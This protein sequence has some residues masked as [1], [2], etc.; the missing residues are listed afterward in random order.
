MWL[1]IGVSGATC[2]GKSSLAHS[3][4]QSLPGSILICQDDFFLP[5]D[6][7]RH[8]IIP[9]LRHNNWEI[10]SSLDMDKMHD[11][12]NDIISDK[13]YKTISLE[14]LKKIA[15]DITNIPEGIAKRNGN[16]EESS[17]VA[18]TDKTVKMNG[19]CCGTRNKE[20]TTPGV[21]ILIIEGFLI[22]NDKILADLCEMKYFL[23]LDRHECWARRSARTYNPPDVPGYFDLCVWPEYVKHRDQVFEEVHNIDIIDGTKSRSIILNHVLK[24]IVKKAEEII[25]KHHK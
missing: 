3:L 23:T 7:K 21:K 9:T 10:M 12:V 16:Y 15:A 13:S 6:D 17:A 1:I 2:S 8:I 4:E 11:R 20:D 14:T 5:E 22:F 24:H 25:E 18:V 19:D